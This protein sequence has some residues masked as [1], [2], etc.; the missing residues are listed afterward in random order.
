MMLD[1][2]DP[3]SEVLEIAAAA[4]QVGRAPA[5]VRDW[6]RSGRLKP[7]RVGGRTYTTAR[8]IRDAER[9]AAGF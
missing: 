6:I 4:A 3:L 9:K 8:A 2:S 7:M 1:D 5:T